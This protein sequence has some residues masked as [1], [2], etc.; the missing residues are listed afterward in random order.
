[1]QPISTCVLGVGL[2]G[3]TFHVPFVL[4]LPDLFSL[5]AVLERNPSSDGGKVR[6]R[7]GIDVKIHRSFEHV[8]ADEQIELVI[9]GTPNATHYE[10]AK[11]CLQANKHVLVDKPAVTTAAE[12]R[13]IGELAQSKGLVLYAYQNRRWDSDF[14]ALKRLLREP[15]SSPVYL[16]DLVEFESHYNRYQTEIKGSWKD[17]NLPGAGQV[18]NLG[19]HLIDQVV[20]LF[21]KPESVTGFV[22][23]IRGIGDPDIDDSFTIILRYPK[24]EQRKYAINVLLRAHILSARDP[25]LRFTV[26]GTGGTF[27]KYGLDVQEAQLKIMP[28]PQDIFSV[29]FGMEPE[30]IWGEV[31]TMEAEGRIAKTPWPT[32]DRGAY[33]E[34]FRNLAGAIRKGEAAEVEWKEVIT[35]LEIIELAHQSS[36]EKRTIGLS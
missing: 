16:G 18:Y 9:I 29:D 22:E 31:Q 27:V 21:G 1:M 19:S 15:A 2:S 35:V 6:E 12:A 24:I 13:E 11:R 34:L 30:D 4:A 25:Q 17:A 28:S 14:L 32:L 36:R 10:Y 8:L 5:H 20:S 7:F 33:V 23:N 26:R 3:L